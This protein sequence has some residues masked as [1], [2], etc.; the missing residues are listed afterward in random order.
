MELI[1]QQ[2]NINFFEKRF[3]NYQKTSLAVIE[4]PQLLTMDINEQ[5]F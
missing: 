4:T 1:S 5:D 2:G 3:D